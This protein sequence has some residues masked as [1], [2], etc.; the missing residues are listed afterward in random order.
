M[1][2]VSRSELN[3]SDDIMR[4]TGVVRMRRVATITP[5]AHGTA[6]SQCEGKVAFLNRQAAEQSAKRPGMGTYRCRYCRH[7]HVGSR[8]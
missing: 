2:T 8:K 5:G 1:P 7:W 6:T 3:A 4:E